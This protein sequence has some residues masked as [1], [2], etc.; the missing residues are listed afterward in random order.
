M[1]DHNAIA[2]ITLIA[3]EENIIAD[4]QK[5]VV[6]GTDQSKL[7][8][9]PLLVV[10]PRNRQTVSRILAYCNAHRLGV[11]PSGGRTGLAGGATA[12]AGEIVLSLEKMNRID[13]VDPIDMCMTVEAGAITETVQQRAEDAGFCFPIDLAA[14]G[15]SQIGGN[16]A[17]N[18]GGMKV[19]RYGMTRENILGLEIVLPDGIFLNLDSRLSKNNTGYDLKHLFIGS[20]GTLGVITAATLHLEPLV[21]DHALVVLTASD[22]NSLMRL[23][24]TLRQSHLPLCACEIMLQNAIRFMVKHNGSTNPFADEWPFYC[25]VEFELN[26]PHDI[27]KVETLLEGLLLD[28]ICTDGI[29]AMNANE[30]ARL[31][32][33]RENISETIG[34]HPH[35][36]KHDI[37]L[38]IGAI[39]KF[40]QELE[41]LWAGESDKIEII[42]FGHFGDGNLH[43]NLAESGQMSPDEFRLVTEKISS[44]IFELVSHFHGS[45]SAEHGIGLLKKNFLHYSRSQLEIEL[46]RKIKAQFDPNNI[47]NRGKI[48]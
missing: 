27:T 1:T 30:R 6:Y 47:M 4:R 12:A 37:A 40:L 31:W 29:Q 17:T 33:I 34:R 10:T 7:A 20:E 2:N 42:V 46:M 25:F 11:V 38:S 41:T 24:T 36:K 43:I 32:K 18:A 5:M 3:G 16:I 48:F 8:G 39:G 13:A 14:R 23:I 15:S 19:L 26:H 35:V 28:G 21:K 9:D 44:K 22:T 45:I